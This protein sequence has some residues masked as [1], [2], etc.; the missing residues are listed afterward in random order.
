[1]FTLALNRQFLFHDQYP[2]QTRNLDLI[3]N[4]AVVA[5]L[6]SGGVEESRCF[7]ELQ[8]SSNHKLTLQEDALSSCL[9]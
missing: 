3:L 8:L 9:K 4:H 6:K 1:M 2:F 5:P 7:L